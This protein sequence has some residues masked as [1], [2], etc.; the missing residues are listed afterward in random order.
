MQ[1][2]F[3]ET[4]QDCEG[5]AGVDSIAAEGGKCIDGLLLQ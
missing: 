2:H 4:N 5:G 3:E 1:F